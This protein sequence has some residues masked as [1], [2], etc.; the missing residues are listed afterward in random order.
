MLF[1]C[2]AAFIYFLITKITQNTTKPCV[3]V[4]LTTVLNFSSFAAIPPS[5]LT[6]VPIIHPTLPPF[7]SYIIC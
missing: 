4:D 6:P 1:L 7:S 5:P 2:C 3:I